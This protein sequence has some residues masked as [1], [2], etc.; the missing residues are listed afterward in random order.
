MSN[1]EYVNRCIKHNKEETI[2]A[3]IPRAEKQ[4]ADRQVK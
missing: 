1:V 2:G 3:P 4:F